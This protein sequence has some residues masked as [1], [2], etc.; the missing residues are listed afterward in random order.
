MQYNVVDQKEHEI[1][2]NYRFSFVTGF[3][4]N[5]IPAW[6]SRLVLE[7]KSLPVLCYLGANLKHL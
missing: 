3:V 2:T 6:I 7:G 1:L 5:P 4:F